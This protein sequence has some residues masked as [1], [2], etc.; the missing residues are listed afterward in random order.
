MGLERNAVVNNVGFKRSGLATSALLVPILLSA[1][2]RDAASAQ[3]MDEVWFPIGNVRWGHT[4]TTPEIRRGICDTMHYLSTRTPIRLTEVPSLSKKGGLSP[5]DELGTL[6]IRHSEGTFNYGYGGQTKHYR[7][8]KQGKKLVKLSFQHVKTR[9][10]ARETLAHEMGH[11]LGFTHEFQ[12][13]DRGEHVKI[14]AIAGRDPYNYGRPDKK[15]VRVLS[16]Y[17]D[18]SQFAAGYDA[19]TPTPRAPVGSLLSVHDINA[20]YRVY[21]RPLGSVADGLRFGEDAATGDF[22]GDSYQDLAIASR[23]STPEASTGTVDFFRGVAQAPGEE[24]TGTTYMPWFR[25]LIHFGSNDTRRIVL[26]SGDTHTLVDRSSGSIADEP[27]GDGIDE[28]IVGLPGAGRIEIWIVNASARFSD[29][30]VSCG[31]EGLEI[32]DNSAPWGGHGIAKILTIRPGDVGATTSSDFGA[33]LA[34]GRFFNRSGDD[35]AIGAPKGSALNV[36]RVDMQKVARTT[37]SSTAIAPRPILQGTGPSVY[38]LPDADPAQAVRINDPGDENASEFGATLAALK[39]FDGRHDTVVVGAPGA[40]VA[41]QADSG[42][43]YVYGRAIVSR[44]SGGATLAP[45]LSGQYPSPNT[46]YGKGVTKGERY[47][48]SI[49]AFSTREEGSATVEHWLAVG[50]PEAS[51][52]DTRC[53]RVDLFSVTLSNHPSNRGSL[54]PRSC[55]AG[56]KFGES[57]AIASGKCTTDLCPKERAWIAVGSPDETDRRGAVYVWDVWAN[58]KVTGTI[59]DTWRGGN[60]DAWFGKRL[61]PVREN[62]NG[63][64]FL[65]L[66]KR[67]DLPVVERTGAVG[68][69]ESGYAQVRLNTAGTSIWKSWTRTLSP[70][71]GADTPPANR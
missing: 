61:V 18:H 40:K 37:V 9:T 42:R 17:D 39:G 1:G 49:V 43:F 4:Q 68:A 6:E 35:L 69:R 66:A 32:F 54:T 45:A 63:G 31:G 47:G 53:G 38:L 22:D 64:G 14:G 13:W 70:T 52:I 34:T 55:E 41:G 28:L 24:G 65:V 30:I 56:M 44:A 33:A 25:Q 2:S 48:T 27:Q 5:T 60:E 3:A 10:R 71:T 16:P 15:N 36:T 57:L 58:G 67:G 8:P 20:I 51:R 23:F 21:G 11:V 7:K 59:A 46:A 62:Q 29:D 19:V 12:R 26:I 50:A